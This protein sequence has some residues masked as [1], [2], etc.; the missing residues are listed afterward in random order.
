V[1]KPRKEEGQG[2]SGGRL[3]ASLPAG[4]ALAGRGAAADAEFA[5]A[6]PLL[7]LFLTAIVD[8]DGKPRKTS[9]LM[10][11]SEDLRFRAVLHERQ[12]GLSLWRDS[13]SVKG[14]LDGLEAALGSGRAEWRRDAKSRQR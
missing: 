14:C 1:S 9:T 6:C 8:D 11:F 4:D 5:A 10:I 2:S 7:H 13:D 3:S 12:H